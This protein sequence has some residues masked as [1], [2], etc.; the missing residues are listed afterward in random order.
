VCFHW[1]DEKLANL[2]RRVSDLTIAE[3]E[4]KKYAKRFPITSLRKLLAETDRLGDVVLVLDTGDWSDR[5]EHAMSRTLGYGPKRKTR[6]VL[7]AY[8]EKDV[9]PIAALSSE[10]DAKILL[11]L[12]LSSLDDAEV[13]ALTKALSPLAVVAGTDRFSPWLAERLHAINTPLIVQTVN[14]HA[15][16]VSLT[17]A[18]ADGFYTDRYV[19]FATLAADPGVA[20][21]CG[22]TKASAQALAPWTTRDLAR[23]QDTLLPGCAKR[24][25]HG[26]ELRDCDGDEILRTYGLPVPAGKSLHVEIDS[27][28]NAAAT[29]FWVELVE[30][31]RDKTPPKLLRAREQIS[32]KPKERR[33]VKFDLD[34]PLG[35]RVEARMGLATKKDTLTLHRLRVFHGEATESEGTVLE[36][37]AGP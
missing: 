7:Q 26:V 31:V 37:D 15:D 16:I 35:S 13:E 1:G 6:I 17:R 34:L 30:K 14:E 10:I 4:G 27:E 21:S 24:I 2:S 29:S 28:A 11:N 8:R 3:I 9:K 36:Q 32:L 5:L 25:G 33:T 12:Q 23:K 20:F 18:G 19:P 22:E